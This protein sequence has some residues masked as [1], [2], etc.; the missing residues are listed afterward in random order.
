MLYTS[1]L[2]SFFTVDISVSSWKAVD[3]LS[4]LCRLL[5]GDIRTYSNAVATFYTLVNFDEVWVLSLD[6]FPNSGPLEE[7][8][9]LTLQPNSSNGGALSD[10]LLDPMTWFGGRGRLS[11][12]SGTEACPAALRF[13]AAETLGAFN[14]NRPIEDSEEN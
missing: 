11:V 2:Y 7:G 9:P 3:H 12:P 1:C 10:L 14:T 4:I 5:C 13:T 8:A 6:T